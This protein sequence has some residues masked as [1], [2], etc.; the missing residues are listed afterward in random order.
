MPTTGSRR[1]PTG[2][3][4]LRVNGQNA[5]PEDGAGIGHRYIEWIEDRVYARAARGGHPV[6]VLVI[7]SMRDY[8]RRVGL[9]I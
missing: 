9:C 8:R 3:R 4:V 2:V 6:R 7:G 1:T 5:T